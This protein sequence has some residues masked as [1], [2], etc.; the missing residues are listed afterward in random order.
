MKFQNV[1]QTT[2]LR[3]VQSNKL[4]FAANKREGGKL[5]FFP[6]NLGFIGMLQKVSTLPVPTPIPYSLH[7]PDKH[8]HE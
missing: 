4:S 7:K 3:S 1:V 5:I 8:K 2:C 6:H